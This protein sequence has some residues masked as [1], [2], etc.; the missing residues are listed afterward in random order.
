MVKVRASEERGHTELGWLDS[1]QTFSFD[2]YHDPRYMGFR[3]L[4][5]INEG[6]VQPGEGVPTHSHRDMEI[7][8][9]LIEGTL[10]HKDSMGHGSVI[11]PGE[12]QR[13]SAGTGITHS[14]YNPSNSEMVH[15]L[16]IW[17]R[18]ETKGLT[19][20]Y[21]QRRFEGAEMRGGLRLVASPDGRARAVTIHQDV[22]LWAAHLEA[23]EKVAH[24]MNPDRHAW[25][26]IVRG[27]LTLNGVSLRTGD[28]A[29][30]S[31]FRA[32]RGAKTRAFR[33]R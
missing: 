11:H 3:H 10:E 23:G 29:A 1:R 30:V 31:G 8:S 32:L 12:V 18:P 19:P 6:R 21:E 17:I 33:D 7:I 27:A 13:M 4:R 2:R 25:L 5:V 24:S 28:G 9:Y 22:E 14:E 26:Q 16:Q 20:S 15:F